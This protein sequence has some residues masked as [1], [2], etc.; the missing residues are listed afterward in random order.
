LSI[1]LP[2]ELFST[3]LAFIASKQRMQI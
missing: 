3:K 2:Q 1:Q